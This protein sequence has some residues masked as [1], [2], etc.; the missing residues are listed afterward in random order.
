MMHQENVK[1]E[2]GFPLNLNPHNGFDSRPLIW[3]LEWPQFIT[4]HL[5]SS[6]NPNGKI[7]NSNLQLASGLIHLRAQAQSFDICE[8][9][10]L[11][12]TNDLATLYWQWKGSTTTDKILAYLLQLFGIHQQYH[13]YVP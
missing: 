13:H 5:V 3:H 11:F 8:R 4:E 12:K 9:T 10:I 6:T 2:C 1:E 7:S